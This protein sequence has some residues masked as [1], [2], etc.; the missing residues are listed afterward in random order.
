MI[1]IGIMLY[2]VRVS[3]HE[4]AKE[5]VTA[6]DIGITITVKRKNKILGVMV[7]ETWGEGS[8]EFTAMNWYKGGYMID[9]KPLDGAY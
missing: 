5:V 4:G 6:S 9:G 8:D 7:V 2:S 3:R 1:A